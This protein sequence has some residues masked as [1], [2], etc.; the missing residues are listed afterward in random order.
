LADEPIKKILPYLIVVIPLFLF[1]S[2]NV[3]YQVFKKPSELI[4]LFFAGSSKTT[5]ETWDAYGDLCRKHETENIS[6]EFL[7]AMA[8]VES[9][10][11]PF[12]TPEWRWRI[13]TDLDQ[14]YAPASSAV[15]LMQYTDDTFKEAKQFCIHDH[16][17][18]QAGSI[19]EFKK[20][21]FNILYT[22]LCPSHSIEVTSARL[23][24]LLKKILGQRGYVKTSD[25]NKIKLAAVIHLCGEGKGKRFARKGF[26]FEAVSPCGT[27]S[28]RVYYGRIRIIMEAMQK[29]ASE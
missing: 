24:Y 23:N 21:W 16:K 5:Q 9:G 19:L 20:C 14:I 18:V 12:S 7:C 29:M 26:D 6:A 27:H 22:R 28:P 2:V 25:E 8:Q 15:G 11:N 13:T 10:G 17:V 3:I 4:S 1:F